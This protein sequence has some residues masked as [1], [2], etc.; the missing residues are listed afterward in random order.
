M[1]VKAWIFQ[2]KRLPSRD[3]NNLVLRALFPG[4]G[5]GFSPPPKHFTSTVR[6]KRPGDEAEIIRHRP[7]SSLEEV[8][9]GLEQ[10]EELIFT[11]L[12]VQKCHIPSRDFPI[13]MTS[14]NAFLQM[15]Y[16]CTLKI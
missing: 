3:F 6:E 5:G 2:L 7:C 4:F 14:Q 10:I 15:G 9:F 11:F 8:C 12:V 13:L 1:Y 16:I